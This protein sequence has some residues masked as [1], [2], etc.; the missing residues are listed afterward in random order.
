MFDF[1]GDLIDDVLSIFGVSGGDVISGLIT[2]ASEFI[3]G[4]PS[5]QQRQTQRQ[6][7]SKIAGG[8]ATGRVPRPDV[9]GAPGVADVDAFHAEWLARMRRFASLAAIVDTGGPR[10][11]G[12]QAR[13]N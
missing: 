3:I 1:I 10:T 8:V 5:G 13:R 11:L 6:P 7:E 4:G 12:T 2:T 9:P